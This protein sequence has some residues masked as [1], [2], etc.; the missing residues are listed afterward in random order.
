MIYQIV[1]LTLQRRMFQPLEEITSHGDSAENLKRSGILS[2]KW[3][4]DYNELAILETIG[5][6][7]YGEVHC[8]DWKGQKVAV[9]LFLQQKL[10]NKVRLELCAE[11]VILSQLHHPNIIKCLGVCA[12]Q[13]NMCMV[14]EYM[15]RGNLK[16]VLQDGSIDLPWPQRLEIALSIAKGMNYLHA[17]NLIHR[18]LKPSNVLVDEDW[19]VKI[20]DFGLS[21][22]KATNQTMTQCGTVAWIAPEIFEGGQY[23]EKADVY[24]YA[25]VLCEI[26]TRQEV[27]KGMHSM[28]ITT[29]VQAGERPKVT[30]S[31]SVSP[32]I[33]EDYVAL[34]AACWAMEPN[35][36]PSFEEIINSLEAIKTKMGYTSITIK[37]IL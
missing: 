36:R 37:D 25:M 10:Q 23:S 31:S 27:W 32:I 4:V 2:R 13:P 3:L 16:Q 19:T 22:I 29:A 24:S 1:G 26:I 20:A 35:K 21:R 8:A 33:K 18:D 12:K 34:M 9:K 28:K 6:G 14:M 11:G 7:S 17:H 15:P 5:I 30:L